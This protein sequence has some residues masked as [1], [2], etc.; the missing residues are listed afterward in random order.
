MLRDPDEVQVVIDVTSCGLTGTP[1]F[2][3]LYK[4]GRI[5]EVE[6][7]KVMFF[8]AH[9]AQTYLQDKSKA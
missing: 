9:C 7:R 8:R 4:G 3:S 2:H 1:Y 6:G 5:E